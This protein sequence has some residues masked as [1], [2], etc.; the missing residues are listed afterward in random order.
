MVTVSVEEQVVDEVAVQINNGEIPMTI[1]SKHAL[2]R[3]LEFYDSSV[4]YYLP[5]DAEAHFN[6]FGPHLR[7]R[8][9]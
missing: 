2:A 1:I 6:V 5:E 4:I 9:K 3:L 8:A 7:A